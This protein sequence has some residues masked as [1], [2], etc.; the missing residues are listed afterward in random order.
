MDDSRFDSLAR[1]LGT[2]G[3][4]R[5]ALG[6]LLAGTL[7]ILGWHD[8]DESA[9]HDLKAKCKKK[10]GEAKKK[11]FK[12]A[13]KHKAAH[14]GEAPPGPTCS[15]GIK[16]GNESGV[17]CGGSCPKCGTG[18]G[19]Q[20]SGDCASGFCQGNVC[21]VPTCS[22]S[23]KNGSESDVDCGGSC[24]RCPNT[25]RC[26]GPNDCVTA[27]CVNTSCQACPAEFAA[28]GTDGSTQCVCARHGFAGELA[29]IN[30]S[31]Q[32][33]DCSG[34]CPSGQVCV[35]TFIGP[36]CIAQCGAP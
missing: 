26:T 31:R 32:G 33:Q 27:Y 16:N 7:G 36:K 15:D 22:D 29:C 19:C 8:G 5:R 24:P 21:K 34:T 20:E 18:Q 9:A 13:K 12:K 10:S 25:K 1:S 14:A 2:A 23:V 3:S 17:D 30:P 35:V 11:C 4:R 6:G 28:C